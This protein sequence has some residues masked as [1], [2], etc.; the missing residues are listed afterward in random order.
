M[1]RAVPVLS[2]AAPAPTD[3]PVTTK[4]QPRR[5]VALPRFAQIKARLR[6]D[7]LDK[8][9]LADQKLPSE[10]RLQQIFGV[11]RITVRQALAELQADG[12]RGPSRGAGR[13][14]RAARREQKRAKQRAGP[15]NGAGGSVVEQARIALWCNW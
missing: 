13:V 12:V 4:P 9:L 8:R 7:I 2:S 1:N 15:L 10:A 14:F 5:P 3:K 11:S 6:Q